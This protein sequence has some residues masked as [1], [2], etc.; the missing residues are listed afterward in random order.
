MTAIDPYAKAACPN[1][2]LGCIVDFDQINL[3]IDGFLNHPFPK[4]ISPL[5]SIIYEVH[6]R[7]FSIDHST[8]SLNKGKFAGFC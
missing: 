3:N 6:I 7:D 4:I 1:G 2:T 8:G 5:E